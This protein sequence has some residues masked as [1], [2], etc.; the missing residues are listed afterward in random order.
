MENYKIKRD[1][2][3]Y[4]TKGRK[5]VYQREESEGA[6]VVVR[7]ALGM[8]NFSSSIPSDMPINFQL[9]F[10]IKMCLGY[11]LVVLC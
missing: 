3:A 7:Y 8:Q 9:K 10:D 11:L 1:V 4:L 2:K 6:Q 5:K